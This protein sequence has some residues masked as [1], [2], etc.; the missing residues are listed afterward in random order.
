MRNLKGMVFNLEFF[1]SFNRLSFILLIVFILTMSSSIIFAEELSISDISFDV[2]QNYSVNKTGEN[3]YLFNSSD[4][5]YTINFV[6][7]ES[8]DSVVGK[9]SRITSGFTFLAEENYT[10]DNNISINQQDFIKNESFFSFYSFNVD[11][12]SYLIIYTFPV[13][14]EVEGNNFNPVL[15]IIDSIH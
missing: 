14:D 8:G 3:S 2:P 15:E 5:N 4:G 6:S 1:M 13:V 12:S 9:N 10:S 11:N 7:V